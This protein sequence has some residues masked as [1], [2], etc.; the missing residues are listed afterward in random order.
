MPVGYYI[1]LWPC[2]FSW[3]TWSSTKSY[4]YCCFWGLCIIRCVFLNAFS[5]FLW[6]GGG[7]ESSFHIVCSVLLHVWQALKTDYTLLNK[8]VLSGF[9]V[10][11]KFFFF[12]LFV[13]LAVCV[14][15]RH[16]LN[17]IKGISQACNPEQPKLMN[18]YQR[19]EKLLGCTSY[20]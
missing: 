16:L 15:C 2:V 3:S 17:G 14:L 6:L 5:L 19:F 13:L 8:V 12:C 20:Y 1:I 7:T 18:I 9:P 4:F 10:F 11:W